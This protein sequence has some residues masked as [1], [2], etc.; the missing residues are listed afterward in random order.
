M[1]SGKPQCIG[2]LNCGKPENL[3]GSCFMNLLKADLFHFIKDK[4]FYVLL[5]LVFLLPLLTCIMYGKAM[6]A[7]TV[8][9]QSVGTSI[10]CPLVGIQL[11]LFF[12][13]DYSNNTI[14]NK[15]CYG[16][17]RYKIVAVCFFES[18]IITFA[19]VAV[20][21]ISSLI[22]GSIVGTFSFSSEFA[23]KFI[24]QLAILI[25]FS[26]MVTANVLC[27]KS[28]K[29]GLIVTLVI[30]IFFM[31]VS[32]L[33]PVLA[34]DNVIARIACRIL[35][36]T[37]S[38]MVTDGRCINGSYAVS[39]DFSFGGMYINALLLAFFYIVIAANVTL[40]VVRKQNYK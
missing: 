32:Y 25:A 16:E 30:S 24:C 40:F 15:I 6:T 36:M 13:K 11:A 21:V 33:L 35:Y 37:V 39:N 17:N 3:V 34:A 26:I 18:I 28:A 7:E 2:K 9:F 4:I 22:F 20:S 38:S 1:L 23:V 31:V 5:T 29:I 14:R 19:F 27:T 10:F 8:I 12:G